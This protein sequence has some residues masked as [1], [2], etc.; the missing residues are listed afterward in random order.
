MPNLLFQESQQG[1]RHAVPKNPKAVIRAL[2]EDEDTYATTLLAWFA[3]RY[4][5]EA[6]EWHP[7][8]VR[9]QLEADAGGEVSKAALDKLLAAITI[10]TTNYFYHSLPKFV[11]ICNILSGDDFDP[12]MFD[13]A[14]AAECAW[15]IVEA[16]MLFPP[17]DEHFDDEIRA[18]VSK[19]LEAEGFT[20][21]PTILR[22]VLK[23]DLPA[24]SLEDFAGD[25][26]MFQAIYESQASKKGEIDQMVS[27]NL[28]E[29]IQQLKALPLVE[30]ST[31]E[32]AQRAGKIFK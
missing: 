9:M 26:E 30:G 13:P 18:Y 8:T 20:Q 4:G 1:Q 23:G 19:V 15:G 27:E 5:P 10:V 32:L 22:K 6:L 25:P 24:S 12:R 3:D 21:P 14:D 2:L 28:N 16:F 17:E 11:Q 7:T 29:L 31:E